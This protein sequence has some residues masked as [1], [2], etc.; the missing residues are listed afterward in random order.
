MLVFPNCKINLGLNVI[1]KRSDGFH[2]IE[3]V[4]YPVPWCDILEIVPS[5]TDNFFFDG[6]KINCTET[7][8]LCFKAYQLLKNQYNIPN[9]NL[10][11]YKNVP[12][13]AGLGGGSSDGAYTILA[14]NTLFSLNIDE[15]TLTNLTSKLGSDCAFFIQ[16]KA[17]YVCETGSH[18]TPLPFNLKGYYLV[19][20]KPDISIPTKDA[21]NMLTPKMPE[22]PLS[23]II[24]LPVYEWKNLLINDFEEPIFRKFPEISFIKKRLYS[25]GAVYASMTGSGSA[26]YGIF[27]VHTDIIDD[28]QNCIYWKGFL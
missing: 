22:I 24:K 14:L 8:N 21:Y 11:L 25:R 16:N 20:I 1:H 15:N 9:I 26:V 17:C 19:I 2:D 18:L 12:F 6:I 13:G 3:S 7:E 27:E 10:Y 23:D 5:E 28:F 4:F